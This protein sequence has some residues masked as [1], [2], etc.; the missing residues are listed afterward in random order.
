MLREQFQETPPRLAPYFATRQMMHIQLDTDMYVHV[1]RCDV[2]S[3][4]S[5]S[6]VVNDVAVTNVIQKT[7]R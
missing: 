6:N 4:G 7:W 2:A 1:V 3:A 5:K